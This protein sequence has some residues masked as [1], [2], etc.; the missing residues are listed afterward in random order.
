M[1]NDATRHRPRV[2]DTLGAVTARPY[3]PDQQRLSLQ[4][5]RDYWTAL[6]TRDAEAVRRLMVADVLVEF[7]FSE[8]GGVQPGEFRQF[9]GIEAVMD[10]WRG[11]AWTSEA[12]GS[13]L[14]D[15]EVTVSADGQIVFIEGFGD[16][17]MTDGQPYHNRYVIRMTVDAGL[18]ASF[19]MYYNPIISAR[20]FRR[21]LGD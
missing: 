17:A 7:P 18:L 16:A 21:A 5:C 11:T 19:R 3:D 14:V 8:S 4:V 6:D 12:E 13:T 1:T 9:R 10:F 15:A 2:S 20:A